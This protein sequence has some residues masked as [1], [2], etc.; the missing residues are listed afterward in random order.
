MF[1]NGFTHAFH[2]LNIM[3]HKSSTILSHHISFKLGY[4]LGLAVEIII[5]LIIVVGVI[6]F[7]VKLCKGEW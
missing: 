4:I 6:E 7:I 1:T 3:I 5:G 2:Q